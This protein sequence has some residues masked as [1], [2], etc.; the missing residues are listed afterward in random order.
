[1]VGAE[2]GFPG[3]EAAGWITLA[4]VTQEVVRH[5]DHEQGQVR[6][7][8]NGGF[9]DVPEVFQAPVLFGGAAVELN[10][11]AQAVIVLALVVGEFQVAAEE[12]DMRPSVRLPVSLDDDDDIQRVRALFVEPWGLVE[13][14]LE[15]AFDGGGFAIPSREIAVIQL[16]A[17]LATWATPGLRAFVGHR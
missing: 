8:S 10:L 4:N 9:G 3:E 13:A 17:I 7:I 6:G 5:S 2:P 14:G 12:D 16:A 11:E 15:G 1:L